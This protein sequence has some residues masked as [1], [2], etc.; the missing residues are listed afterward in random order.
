MDISHINGSIG[1]LINLT[2]I[3]I[4]NQYERALAYNFMKI[5]V[6]KRKKVEEIIRLV[7]KEERKKLWNNGS[8]DWTLSCFFT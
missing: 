4:K 2:K 3:E 7:S 8:K 5:R 1:D 6:L